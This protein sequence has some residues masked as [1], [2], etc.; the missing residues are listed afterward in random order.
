VRPAA[1]RQDGDVQLLQ[2]RRPV[3][4]VHDHLE[5]AVLAQRRQTPG[6]DEGVGGV[7]EHAQPPSTRHRTG[8]GRPDEPEGIGHGR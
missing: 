1:L 8:L 5:I 3:P 7:D 2:L 4:L 6:Q